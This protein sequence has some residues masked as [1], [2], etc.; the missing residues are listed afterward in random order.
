MQQVHYQIQRDAVVEVIGLDTGRS[1]TAATVYRPN[2]VAV[3]W[4]WCITPRER[5]L[6]EL[7]LSSSSAAVW[8]GIYVRGD[9]TAQGVTPFSY[10]CASDQL[11]LRNPN[12]QWAL[13]LNS[14]V[15]SDSEPWGS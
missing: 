11:K 10:S 15:R 7:S 8:R 3:E 12:R 9:L 6:T 13:P 5:G 2:L 14:P 1:I 4:L